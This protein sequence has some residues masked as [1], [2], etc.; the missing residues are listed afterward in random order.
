MNDTIF[1]ADAIAL[2]NG[3]CHP[4]NIAEE[5]AKLPSAQPDV[6]DTN[7]GDLISRQAAIDALKQQAETMSEWSNRYA[8]Q[9]KGVLTAVNIVEDLPSAHRPVDE[10]CT[11]CKE[12]DHDKHCCPRFNRVIRTAVGE[13][14]HGE[15]IVHENQRQEDV[16]NGNYL[17]VC[18]ECGKSDIHAKTQ[19]VPYCWWCGARMDGDENG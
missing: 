5:L 12:Y 9:K 4:A 11:D 17:Y 6:P 10:W 18:S 15:W 13:Q 14:K 16:D 1:R 7:V 19:K 3:G 8:E 2:A